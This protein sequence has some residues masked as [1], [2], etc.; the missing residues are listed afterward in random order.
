MPATQT[1]SRLSMGDALL[2]ADVLKVHSLRI[3]KD[4]IEQRCPRCQ[5]YLPATDEHFP[6]HRDRVSG[7][8][9]WCRDCK[10][11]HG[12]SRRKAGAL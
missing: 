12:K 7:L 1:L 8:N 10:A 11:D 9:S 2:L 4:G 3:G 6:P 5:L